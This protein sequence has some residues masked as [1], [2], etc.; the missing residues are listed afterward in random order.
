MKTCVVIPSKNEAERI[1]ELVR[2]IKQ[3]NLDAIVIDDGSTDKTS[4]IARESGAIVLRNEKNLGKGLALRKAFDYILTKDYAGVI[5]IDGDGQHDPA[6]IPSFIEKAQATGAGVIVGNRMI[7]PENMPFIRW[8]TNNFMSMIISS[9]SRQNIPDSQCGYRYI[10]INVLKKIKLISKKFEIESEVL[11]EASRVG[12]IIDSVSI[13][14]IYQ[15]QT[16][17][18]NPLFDTLRFLRFIIRKT[19]FAKI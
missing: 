15:G 12:Y 1:G 5:V 18:I 7:K 8:C 17:K 14:S 3:L 13:K 19:W 4:E 2:K 16:S 10:D 6:N 9:I 11:I